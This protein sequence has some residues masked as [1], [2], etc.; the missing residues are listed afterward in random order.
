MNCKESRKHM[1]FHAEGTLDA[2][3]AGA[4]NDHL[5]H[6]EACSHVYN[7][8]QKTL[9]VLEKPMPVRIDPWFAGRVEARLEQL[10]QSDF[11]KTVT[12]KTSLIRMI[13]VAASLIIALWLGIYIGS[14]LPLQTADAGSDTN[15]T[16]VYDELI[17]DDLYSE[18]IE[19]FF[20]TNGN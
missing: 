1:I 5:A 20:L 9:E 6:C 14:N 8:V 16:G 11:K 3:L 7:E 10:Q 15:S 18:S 17:A 4:L 19:A 2:S 12:L 13:P